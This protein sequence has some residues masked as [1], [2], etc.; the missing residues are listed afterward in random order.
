MQ[1]IF[2][3]L[4]CTLIIET[5]LTLLRLKPARIIHSSSSLKYT[6]YSA[7]VICFSNSSVLYLASKCMPSIYEVQ[8][9]AYGLIV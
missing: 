2:K 1:L 6:K 9:T 8:N 4:I 5:Y 3:P 7:N